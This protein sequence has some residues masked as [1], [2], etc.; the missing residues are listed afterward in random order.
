MKKV[1]LVLLTFLPFCAFAVTESPDMIIKKNG[2]EVVK[3]H[4]TE[5]LNEIGVDAAFSETR[6]IDRD[7]KK[8]FLW[9]GLT[10]SYMNVTEGCK[11]IV[12][13]VTSGK[14]Y[15]QNYH[16][17]SQ[18]FESFPLPPYKDKS[19]YVIWKA[20][21]AMDCTDTLPGIPW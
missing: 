3:G 16:H 21:A 13:N 2:E 11:A 8:Y 4:I 19:T 9:Q 10:M 7:Y 5:Y 15:N 17:I 18:S 20:V 6:A 1:T 14:G 12:I